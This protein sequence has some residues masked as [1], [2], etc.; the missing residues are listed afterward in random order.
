MP[1]IQIYLYYTD[2]QNPYRSH[3]VGNSD[4]TSKGII[5]S[6]MGFLSLILYEVQIFFKS[7]GISA[8]KRIII[9]YRRTPVIA[10]TKSS[11]GTP[12]G[13]PG[14]IAISTYGGIC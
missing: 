9:F 11:E 2:I 1:D 12:T 4:F 8:C 14:D 5:F 10:C 13:I 6:S 7:S 3:Y